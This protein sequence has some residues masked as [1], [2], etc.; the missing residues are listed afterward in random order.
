[1]TINP[2]DTNYKLNTQMAKPNCKFINLLES[3]I[4]THQYFAI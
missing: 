3:R 2:L 1:M 4:F